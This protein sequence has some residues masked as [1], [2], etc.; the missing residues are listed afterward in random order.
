MLG[1]WWGRLI[2]SLI[3]YFILLIGVVSIGAP[4]SKWFGFTVIIIGLIL[5]EVYVSADK[6]TKI[7][8]DELIRVKARRDSHYNKRELT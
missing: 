1:N 5:Y 6:K 3:S 4:V 2:I 8:K 7:Y